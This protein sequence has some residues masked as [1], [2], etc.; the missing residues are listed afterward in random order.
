MFD[1]YINTATLKK[2]FETA[3]LTECYAI[4]FVE[5]DSYYMVIPIDGERLILSTWRSEV[6]KPFR[7][8]DSLIKEAETFGF[9]SIKFG[10]SEEEWI[11]D[12]S[13]LLYSGLRVL[14]S[15]I[16]RLPLLGIRLSMSR[17]D[18]EADTIEKGIDEILS[19]KPLVVKEAHIRRL[20]GNVTVDD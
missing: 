7:K 1:G 15:W 18:Y 2:R 5:S 8:A 17:T 12:K 11:K 4:R 13:N 6:A 3:P 20:K 9:T 14:E 19:S 16:S 10:S